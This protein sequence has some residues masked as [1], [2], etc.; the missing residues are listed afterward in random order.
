MNQHTLRTGI[1]I[2]RLIETSLRT[3]PDISLE[4]CLE[5]I[6]SRTYPYHHWI[7]ILLFKYKYN[8]DYYIYENRRY[9]ICHHNEKSGKFYLKKDSYQKYNQ[10]EFILYLGNRKVQKYEYDIVLDFV[11]LK[12]CVFEDDLSD[13]IEISIPDKIID[14]SIPEKINDNQLEIY[15]QI[16]SGELSDTT[17]SCIDGD[18]HVSKVVLSLHSPYFRNYFKYKDR[19]EIQFYIQDIK[20]YL[21]YCLMNKINREDI[22]PE[23]IPM[24]KYF[25]D[26]TFVKYIYTEMIIKID[27][28]KNLSLKEKLESYT[29]LLSYL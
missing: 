21:Y 22:Y 14:I 18:V 27:E 4:E 6:D 26:D 28:D 25:L 24:G 8:Q 12:P 19:K 20:H 1:K 10:S 15:H 13:Y 7:N 17:L 3:Y 9:R 2:R 29:N 11:T 5:K 23:L 16:I